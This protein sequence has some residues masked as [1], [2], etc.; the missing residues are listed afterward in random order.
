MPVNF[1]ELSALTE[2]ATPGPWDFRLGSGHHVMTALVH[3]D[4]Q[5]K[6]TFVAD[7]LPEWALKVAEPDHRPNMEFVAACRTAVPEMIAELSQ[8][9]TVEEAAERLAKEAQQVIDDVNDFLVDDLR[10][11]LAAFHATRGQ[12]GLS[13]W[14]LAQKAMEALIRYENL[15]GDGQEYLKA[16]A[17]YLAAR[18]EAETNA[19]PS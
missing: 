10:T 14:E 6:N 7:F 9:R 13:V 17:A 2:K 3:E 15:M 12:Q 1:E 16:K 11:A 4:E 18:K 8:L 19:H 5:G